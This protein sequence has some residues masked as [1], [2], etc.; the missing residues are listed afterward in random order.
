[1]QHVS[2]QCNESKCRLKRQLHKRNLTVISFNEKTENNIIS[3]SKIQKNHQV[4]IVDSDFPKNSLKTDSPF[5][6]H[7]D[8]LIRMHQKEVQAKIT[9]IDENETNFEYCPAL[10]DILREYLYIVP[11]WT[12]VMM[13]YRKTLNPK[14]KKSHW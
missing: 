12:G 13:N 3:K 1:M 4:L 2:I 5:K 9:N 6:V 14:Y 8:K 7:F 10:F 11:F